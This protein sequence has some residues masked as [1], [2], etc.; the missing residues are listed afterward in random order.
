MSQRNDE[1]SP[2]I[3]ERDANDVSFSNSYNNEGLIMSDE[4]HQ[5]ESN[6]TGTEEF[7]NESTVS[8]LAGHSSNVAGSEAGSEAQSEMYQKPPFVECRVCQTEINISGRLHQHVVRCS[9]GEAT[10][11]R[12]APPGKKYVRCPCNCL[13]ICK[14]ASARIACPRRN[15]RR[16]ITLGDSTPTG[17]ASRAPPGTSRISCIH[18][19]EVFMFNT[20]INRVAQCPHCKKESSVGSRFARNRALAY[21]A[22]SIL[23]VAL[24]IVLTVITAQHASSA[25]YVLYMLYLIGLLASIVLAWKASHFW[26]LKVSDNLGAL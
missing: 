1:R 17:V 15:C 26:R 12:S 20:L 8:G 3:G 21:S 24:C 10:P 11:I 2:L 18:C 4:P 23:G 16:V 22:T 19:H 14:A 9:C 5:G 13:L 7:V 6:I 25:S